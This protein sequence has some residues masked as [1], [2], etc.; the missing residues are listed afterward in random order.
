[1]EGRYGVTVLPPQIGSDQVSYKDQ[2]A[3]NSFVDSLFHLGDS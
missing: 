2:I 3:E 1:M